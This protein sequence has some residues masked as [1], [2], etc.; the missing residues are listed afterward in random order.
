MGPRLLLT[1]HGERARAA[2]WAAVDDAKAGDPLAPVTVAVPST[3]AGLGLRR[4]LGRE[5]GLV[6]VRFTALARVAELLGA[7]DLAAAGRRPLAG[8]LL[9]EAVYATLAAEPGFLSPV[10]DHPS[11]EQALVATFR[12][13][14]DA[15]AGARASLAAG[16]DGR[17]A[18]IL[19]L[20]DAFRSRT[21]DFY[22]EADL[23]LAAAAAV[24]TAPERLADVGHVVVHLP[25]KL[26]EADARLVGALA[27]VDRVTVVLGLTHDSAVDAAI[28]YR[29][30]ARLEPALG[31]AHAT[32]PPTDLF[33]LGSAPPVGT[34][35]VST[36][37]PEDEVRAVA[38]RI[39]GRAERGLPLHRIAVVARVEEPYGRLVPEVLDGAGI[40]WNGATPRRLA[41]T[42]LGRVLRGLLELAEHEFARDAVAAWLAAGPILDPADGRSVDAARADALSREAG[43]VAGAE[44]WHDRLERHA[45]TLE[46][47]LHDPAAAD[48]PES[49]R[50]GIE[51]DVEAVRRLQSFVADLAKHVEPPDAPSWRAFTNW[52]T[53]LL[54]RYLGPETRWGQW[55]DA[56]LE[57][58][59]EARTAVEHLASLD[60]FETSVDL[61]RFRRAVVTALDAPTTRSGQFGTGVF[62]G[63]L[64]QAYAGD[65]DVVYVLGTVEG[66]FPP[67]GREDPLLPDRDRARVEGLTLHR[68]RRDEERHEYLAALASAPE[69]VLCFARA[70][71][72]AQ[73]RLLPS[74][75]LLETARALRAGEV[76]AEGLRDAVDPEPWLDVVASF[77]AGI[78]GDA[79]PASGNEYD[80]CSL[81]TWRES[82]T[83]V[84]GH[85][86]VVADLRAG[87]DG[88]FSRASGG[89]TAYDGHVE[90][91]IVPDPD[92]RVVSPTSLEAWA[93]CPFRYLLGSVLR[94]RDRP[95]PEEIE[96]ITALDEGS[97]IHA[98]LEQF[99]R[100]APPRRT[101]DEPWDASDRAR[102]REIVDERCADAERRGITGRSVAWLL[103]RRRIDQ[104]VERFL[105]RDAEIRAE[106]GVVPD[107][108]G[109]ELAFGLDGSA[110]VAVTLG[111]GR[112]VRFRG[113]IDRVDRSPD[114]RRVVVY[115]Y[116]TGSNRAFAGLSDGDPVAGGTKLQLPV[117]ALAAEQHHGVSD[118]H[119]YYWFT[120]TDGDPLV[121]YAADHCRDR[122]VEALTTIED[123]V[124]LG[125]FPA[126]PG[127][128]S[129][130]P[131]QNRETFDHCGYCEFDRLCS[132]D[133]EAAWQRKRSAPGTEP[134]LRLTPDDE[135]DDEAA[136]ETGVDAETER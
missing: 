69:R 102:M 72:R 37:D 53:G 84:A 66:S 59:R 118:A 92:G 21:R 116:K 80:L 108:E 32:D 125:C 127:E 71:A 126:V 82:N 31:A 85:P 51:R 47:A 124:A 122:F 77:E 123:G 35:V 117:Y 48:A 30:A 110:P 74:R 70:D 130:N 73:R 98:I 63:T 38:R 36:S 129:W 55:P 5:R 81:L 49:R 135:A 25:S 11:T 18:T 96:S 115:D 90:A 40:P 104:T 17:A 44:Q 83:T 94:L 106:L 1:P 134:F 76:T 132:V 13:L 23:A 26:S 56:E 43:V 19:R 91:G 65:F 112:Q 89:F 87:F 14:R 86:L 54:D 62:V 4:A 68:A 95:R 105:E 133:R 58:G 24:G 88:V 33:S 120:A 113:R 42:T 15:S 8:P 29:L 20:Y 28:A 107:V 109:L 7:P 119:A 39:A 78:T 41:D 52:A 9:G 67:R 12:D 121:G 22:D 10:A 64:R 128:R 75:W 16:G 57:T 97:L 131:R 79:E 6:N 45:R 60:E 61:A 27:A 101:P 99:V 46:D 136:G 100:D 103:A 34:A 3:Y 50:R 111:D 2:L 114:G 93:T